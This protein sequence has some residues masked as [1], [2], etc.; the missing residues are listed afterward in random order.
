M[1]AICP[2]SRAATSRVWAISAATS[3]AQ[4]PTPSRGRRSAAP[5]AWRPRS[6]PGRRRR[7]START[8]PRA[9]DAG[10]TAASRS[11]PVVL[12]RRA[13]GRRGG[14]PPR[15]RCRRRTRRV[16]ELGLQR[17]V[18]LDDAVVDHR[19]AARRVEVG[20]GVAVVRRA[21]GRPAGVPDADPPAR[22]GSSVEGVA[23]LPSLPAR[24]TTRGPLAVGGR[25]CRPS[26][27]R[28]T[29]AAAG[30]R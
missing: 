10:R 23:R 22:S 28:G 13:R 17:L 27:S 20:V 2:S 11:G 25:R 19:D 26:R 29:R 3:E 1:R 14:R 16:A 4:Y 5:R 21:V 12:R 9:G 30:R 7:R 8:P 24:L 18:V 6:C 15:C